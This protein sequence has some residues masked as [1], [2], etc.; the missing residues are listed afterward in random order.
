[1]IP[2]MLGCDPFPRIPEVESPEH[3]ALWRESVKLAARAYRDAQ[4]CWFCYA[5]W[6]N[7]ECPTVGCRGPTTGMQRRRTWEGPC[8]VC[9]QVTRDWWVTAL[10]SAG[11]GE[12]LIPEG[13]FLCGVCI[14]TVRPPAHG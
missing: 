14:S 2:A 13:H 4:R 5:R 8:V 1:M 12:L 9:K 10:T 6:V 3:E 7:G 11:D